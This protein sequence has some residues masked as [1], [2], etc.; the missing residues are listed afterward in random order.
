MIDPRV[1]ALAKRLVGVERGIRAMS[2]PQ[3][4]FSS[5]DN[6]ALRATDDSYGETMQIG[7]QW[8]GTYAPGVTNGP[9]PPTPT[10]PSV[11]DGTESI[12]V[13]W[14]G[15]FA[16]G[17]PAPMDWLRV[18][19][20]VGTVDTFVPTHDNRVGTIAA[21]TGGAVT[22]GLTSGTYF[23]KLVSW[24]LAGKV[25]LSS[26]AVEGDAWPVVAATDGFAP[27]S[28][29]AVELIGGLDI[30]LARW[31][32]ITNADPVTYE[33]HISDTTGFTPDSTTLAG[34]TSATA[35]TIKLLP[36]PPPAL[37]TDEDIRKLLYDTQYYVKIVAR[38]ADGAAA[39]GAQDSD[40]IFQVTGVNLSADSVT[41]AHVQVGTLTGD[42]FSASVIIS[43]AFRTAETGQ[44]VEMT[45]LGF[46]AYKSDGSIMLKIPTDSPD[47]FFDGELIVRGATILGGMSIRSS[48]N[49]VTADAIL[50]LMRGI[51]APTA[52]PQFQITWDTVIPSTTSL[53]A[54]Q[55]TTSD[56][57]WTLGA[58]FDLVASEVVYTRWIAAENMWVFFQKRPAGT[59][60]W[61]FNPD[62]T[63]KDRYGGG[64]TYCTDVRDWEIWSEV[65]L[66]T[67]P[68]KNGTYTMFRYLPTNTWYV[69]CPF[70]LKT[71][72]R[73]NSTQ[74]PVIGHNGTDMYI[75]EVVA[76]N[77][78]NIRYF[79]PTSGGSGAMPAPFVAYESSQGYNV[80][81]PLANVFQGVFDV[82][83]G[84]Y[85]ACE[86]GVSNNARLLNTSGTNANSIFPGGS[87]NSWTSSTKEAESFESPATRQCTA[88]DG[89]N[90]WTYASD[91]LMYK[92]TAE[93][94]DP[95]VVSSQLWGR[96]TFRDGDAGGTGTHETTP[97]PYKSFMHKR[98]AK[99]TWTCPTVPDNGGTDDPDRACLYMGRGAT[100][101]ANTAMYKQYEGT[102]NTTITTLT[103]AT[104]NPPTV[105][106]FPAS[107]PAKITN[108]NA[109]LVIDGTGMGKFNTLF[110]GTDEILALEPYWYGYLNATFTVANN[111]FQTINNWIAEGTPNSSGITISSGVFT[112]PRAGRYN[113][114]AQL[115]WNPLAGA[116][117]KRVMQSV[118][119]P[120]NVI[121]SHTCWPSTTLDSVNQL[122]KDVRL[123]AGATVFFRFLHQQGAS[124]TGCVAAGL[125]LSWVQ[126]KY[127]GP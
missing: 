127:I 111:T 123:A 10:N 9:I 77:Q 3:L 87:G 54:A 70:G 33:V 17:A 14:D 64:S 90:F 81:I 21:P 48:Q 49:E 2:T 1:S 109:T 100:Q 19:I 71:Y 86:R 108:D 114:K 66:T 50:T 80:N 8:D 59:R 82:G 88:W 78:M 68:G 105:N 28:S 6:G 18:D 32:A 74:P 61:Y 41:A 113:L 103:T 121:Q 122:D 62:G 24:T 116:T 13:L 37:P 79:T 110:I 91:G 65:E 112:A 20:H 46:F 60:V 42:L 11:L 115:Y 4:A 56:P 69:N 43:G 57:A 85:L 63:P 58:P 102:T 75:A 44:R 52:T 38:D 106:S 98:R 39:P 95:S 31:Q 27:A 118:V 104:A 117:G 92:H 84:R 5:I 34:T 35:F 93:K 53:T 96:V 83:S 124:I 22:I 36:G 30:L 72:T 12:N 47:A 76:T 99:F 89:T 125:D 94:W 23:V 15:T 97:G 67:S 16:G 126:V 7:R 45:P 25:S 51:V 55:K 101:P 40:T 29:P 26:D 107:N 119:S 73:Q 120:F